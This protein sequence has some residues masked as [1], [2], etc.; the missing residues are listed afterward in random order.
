MKYQIVEV[1]N[2]EDCA[3]IH[4]ELEYLGCTPD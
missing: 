2:I 1:C 4:Y 3:K